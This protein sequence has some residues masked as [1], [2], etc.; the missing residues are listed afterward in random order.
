MF[1]AVNFFI[2]LRKFNQLDAKNKGLHGHEIIC[3]GHTAQ[4]KYKC[5]Y[6]N[7][8]ARNLLCDVI[9]S[10]LVPKFVCN[11]KHLSPSILLIRQLSPGTPIQNPL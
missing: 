10:T 7:K 4:S 1:F 6:P 11:S 2:S 9:I 5:F 8:K 3:T